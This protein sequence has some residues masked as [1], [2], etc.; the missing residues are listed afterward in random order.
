VAAAAQV[1]FVRAPVS[2]NPVV[3]RSGNLTIMISAPPGA[4]DRVEP[5]LRAIGPNHY[6]VG[7]AEEARVVKL[8]LQV[9]IAGTAQL[10]AEAIALGEAGG[11][12]RDVLLQ[13]MGDS[14]A[15][16]PFVRYK[17]PPLLADDYGATF[18]LEM[19]KKDLELVLDLAGGHALDLPAAVLID[20]LTGA[21]VAAGYGDLDM[22]ALLP[23]LRER[24]DGPRVRSR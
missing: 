22:M 1:D 19:L 7:E 8:V 24:Q 10:I 2:G 12:G 15:G 9:M 4:Y 11:V 23:A 14:A 5:V 13:V 3:V 6:V 17:T 21:A 20:G 18:T 16:S